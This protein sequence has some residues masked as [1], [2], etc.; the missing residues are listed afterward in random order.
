MPEMCIRDR[1]L[2]CLLLEKPDMLFLDEPT[3]HLDIGTLKWLEQY[4]RGY[5]GTIVMVSHDRSFL[6]Q[7]ATR[8]FDCL[9]YTSL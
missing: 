5:K 2:A 3:N 1:A 8:I 9:L 6:D 7:M 4:L